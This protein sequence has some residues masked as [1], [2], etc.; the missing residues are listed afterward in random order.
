MRTHQLTEIII[1][2][3]CS[4]NGILKDFD[5]RSASNTIDR[6]FNF[7]A[8]IHLEREGKVGGGGDTLFEDIFLG[9]KPLFLEY[10]LT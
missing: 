4:P 9:E 10:H 3:F 6:K 1:R 7:F 2:P 5:S 8:L